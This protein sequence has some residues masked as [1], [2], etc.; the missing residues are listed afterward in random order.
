MPSHHGPTYDFV[1]IGSGFG[2]SVSALRLAEK[3]YSVFALERGKHYRDQ[4]FARSNWHIWKYLWLPALRWFGILEMSLLNGMMV[5]HGSGVGGGSLGYANALMEPDDELFNA[6]AWRDLADW[7]TILRPHFATAKRMLGVTPNPRLWPADSILREVASEHGKADSLHPADVG[8]YFGDEER[9][10]T[11]PYS[12]GNGPDR[13]GCRHYGGCMVG[14][15]YNAKNTLVKNY[16][17]LAQKLVRNLSTLFRHKLSSEKTAAPEQTVEAQIDVAHSATRAF[18]AKANAVPA[19]SIFESLLNLPTTAHVLGG[20]P[21]GHT[22]HEG[23][24]DLCGQMFGYPG[25][26]VV[27]GSIVPANPGINPSLTITALAEY[28]MSCIPAK[29]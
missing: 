28:T 24:V 18:A 29:G 26:Y 23:V 27:D 22:P 7:K 20:C 15:R 1:V 14:C 10:T 12:E 19:G 2:G 9:D 21:L 13:K 6:P 8:V 16:L 17:C 3:G 4:D 5:L 25:L 11:D